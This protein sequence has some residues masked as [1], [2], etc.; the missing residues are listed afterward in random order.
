MSISIL[1]LS[2]CCGLIV[3]SLVS[4]MMNPLFIV[5]KNKSNDTEDES[6]S[7]LHPLAVIVLVNDNID[8]LERNIPLFLEQEY[9]PGY[10]IIIVANEGD[11]LADDLM[12]RY[13]DHKSL[14]STFIP[15]TSRYISREKLGVTLG[16]KAARHE[17]CILVDA[18]CYPK[19]RYWLS[20]MSKQCTDSH[21]LVV[22]YCN[23]ADGTKAYRLFTRMRHFAYIWRD[24]IKGVPYASNNSNLAFRKSDFINNEGYRGNLECIRGE[25]DFIVNKFALK[26]K[27][28][29]VTSK[30]GSLIESVPTDKQ[31]HRRQI[32]YIH[33]RKFMK[34]G[35]WHQVLSTTDTVLLHLTWIASMAA[36]V[37]AAFLQNWIL[38]ISAILAILINVCWRTLTGR[39][40]AALLHT[41]VPTWQII[42]LELSSIWHAL[43]DKIHYHRANPYDFTCHKL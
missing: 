38:L 33:S 10:Q 41:D 22:G 9:E 29:V 3:L 23:Y 30:E 20:E 42:P 43:A 14:K 13:Q 7:P 34:H 19:S 4:S 28:G 26:N 8:I 12:K 16:V 25:Y 24:A 37:I 18:L 15:K 27:T 2:I 35:T 40:V 5:P 1:T 17:W 39:K 32:F 36:I 6:K 31:W 11:T 21:N